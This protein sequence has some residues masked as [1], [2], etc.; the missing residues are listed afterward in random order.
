MAAPTLESSKDFLQGKISVWVNAYE[1]ESV[2]NRAQHA[3]RSRIP[4][5][6]GL[7]I[8]AL[9]N[10]RIFGTSLSVD[11][12]DFSELLKRLKTVPVD[13]DPIIIKIEER[14]VAALNDFYP[15]MVRDCSLSLVIVCPPFETGNEFLAPMFDVWAG[16][17]EIEL[18]W[19][20]ANNFEFTVMDIRKTI[21]PRPLRVE[22]PL[23]TLLGHYP[24]A[25]SDSSGKIIVDSIARGH[26]VS[27]KGL[28]KDFQEYATP[29]MAR[30]GNGTNLPIVGVGKMETEAF[31]IPGVEFAPDLKVNF[32]SVNQLDHDHHLLFCFRNKSLEI[33]KEDG[34]AVGAGVQDGNGTYVLQNLHVPPQVEV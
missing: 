18:T 10:S 28:L 31:N 17:E 9:S 20:Q 13:A 16:P 24:L 23:V 15:L 27:N 5:D 19:G 26:I 21:F 32:I 6:A 7:A 29:R 30:L 22:V 4:S 14:A 8:V 34:T 11:S 12:S 33:R 25:G 3:L 1:K 2:R